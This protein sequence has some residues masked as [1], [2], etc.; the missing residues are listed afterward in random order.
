MAHAEVQDNREEELARRLDEEVKELEDR[1][2]DVRA[3]RRGLAQKSTG[4]PTDPR[5]E[6][7]PPPDD[8]KPT[9]A[10]HDVL[11]L[12]DSALPLGS[13]AFSS[14]LESYLAHLPRSSHSRGMHNFRTFLTLSLAS[15]ASTALPYVV[16]AHSSAQQLVSLD[17]DLDA[18]IACVVVKR[19]SVAQGRAL[20]AMWERSLKS[21]VVPSKSN[22]LRARA[23][24]E[25]FSR[26]IKEADSETA[27]SIEH[28]SFHL[29]PYGHLPPLF[30]D[31]CAAMGLA[32]RETLYL[33][34]LN[35]AK[36][37]LSA[38]IRA[39]VFGPYQSQGILISAWL[40]SSL[41]GH[42]RAELGSP[43]TTQ[44]AAQSVPV[45]DIWGGRHEILY[46]R[47]FNS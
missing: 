11:I 23:A 46:S 45:L 29:G 27:M 8:G 7:N 20:L 4:L 32:L 40:R 17:N 1:L 37:L 30:G 9:A 43:R 22:A 33:Y 24:L 2:H 14:G 36:T 34:L 6:S 44:D 12:S 15:L 42:V 13:F 25:D 18:S 47:I 39:S 28:N 10:F 26:L 19:A 5:P 21:H 41:E 35:H 3:R 31:L 38:G 16:A